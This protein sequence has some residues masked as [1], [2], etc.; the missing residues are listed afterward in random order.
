[1]L[2]SNYRD[3]GCVLVRVSRVRDLDLQQGVPNMKKLL[4]I[5]AGAL[6]SV[7]AMASVIDVPEPGSLGLLAMGLAG[8]VAARLRRK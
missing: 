2:L 7:P 4:L 1:M 6:A 3:L 8:V 5:A